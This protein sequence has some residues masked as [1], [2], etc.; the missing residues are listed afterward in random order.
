MVRLFFWSSPTVYLAEICC[1]NLESAKGLAQCKSGPGNN[2]TEQIIEFEVTGTGPSGRSC[3]PINS[4][5][6]EKAKN[7]QVDYYF[8]LKYCT[9]QCTML[10][11]TWAKITHKF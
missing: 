11:A 4:Y 9:R 6:Y 3:I 8:L 5:F 10:S 2:M 1:E 7:L